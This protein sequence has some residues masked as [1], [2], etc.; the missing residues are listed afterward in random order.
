MGRERGEQGVF[1]HSG[2]SGEVDLHGFRGERHPHLFRDDR[3]LAH[4]M[5]MV[6]SDRSELTSD[7]F[8]LPSHVT[9]IGPRLP[10]GHYR[11][12]FILP[13]SSEDVP[14]RFVS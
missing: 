3:L 2:T 1:H 12:H 7:R 10:R 4:L 5:G 6:D 8:P 14:E 9:P 13:L 11:L